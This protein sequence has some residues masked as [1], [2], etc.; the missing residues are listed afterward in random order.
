MSYT[1]V[2][3]ASFYLTSIEKKL[4]AIKTIHSSSFISKAPTR[5][6]QVNNENELDGHLKSEITRQ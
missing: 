1:T 4:A 5:L 2:V 3:S 6:T